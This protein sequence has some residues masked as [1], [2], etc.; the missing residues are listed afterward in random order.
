DL[1]GAEYWTSSDALD[2]EHAQRWVAA[3][4]LERVDARGAAGPPDRLRVPLHEPYECGLRHLCDARERPLGEIA[5]C[6]EP[7]LLLTVAVAEP[8]RVHQ[9]ETG[10]RLRVGVRL[11]WRSEAVQVHVERRLTVEGV[12]PGAAAPRHEQ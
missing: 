8:E 5:A 1:L 12:D 7:D 9:R 2:R 6:D 10:E 4:R 11:G 3:E